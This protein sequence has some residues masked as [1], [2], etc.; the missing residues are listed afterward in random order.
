MLPIRPGSP[1]AEMRGT[2][3][4]SG[5]H[6]FGCDAESLPTS[7]PIPVEDV[8]VSG[9]KSIEHYGGWI[10][11]EFFVTRETG[12][13]PA[14]VIVARLTMTN[15]TLVDVIEKEIRAVGAA[16][17]DRQPRIALS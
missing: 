1:A 12:Y 9:L 5:V 3:R 8:F 15:A 13:G 6:D 7:E 4:M 14:A 11:A 16:P 2:E 17:F 10:R